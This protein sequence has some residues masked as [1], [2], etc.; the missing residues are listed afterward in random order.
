MTPKEIDRLRTLR[1]LAKNN[2]K[3]VEPQKYGI[4]DKAIFSFR[5]LH[6]IILETMLKPK[7]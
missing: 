6:K 1:Q 5:N 2:K 7:Q 3:A 4:V